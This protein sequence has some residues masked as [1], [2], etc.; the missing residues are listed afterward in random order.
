MLILYL[1]IS[2]PITI[3]VLPY[4]SFEYNRSAIYINLAPGAQQISKI[5]SFFLSSNVFTVSID[6]KSIPYK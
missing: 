1:E 5:L 2:F 3:P 4:K 6:P